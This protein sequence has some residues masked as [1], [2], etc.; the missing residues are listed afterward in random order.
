MLG[1]LAKAGVPKKIESIIV[2]ESLFNDGIGV[3][4]FIAL[5]EVLNSGSH[6]FDFSHFSILFLREA[7]GGILFGLA[8]GYVLHFI[9][10]KIDHYE[11]EV[12]LT[13]AFV[14]G[15]YTLAMALHLSGPLAMV[16]MGLLIGNYKGEAFMSDLTKEYMYK[17]WE[18]IDMIL[19]AVLFI[20]IA[21]VLVVIDFKQSYFLIAVASVIII[22]ISRVIVVYLPKILFIKMFGINNTEAKLLVWGGL[23]GGLSIALALS[24][25][26]SEEKYIILLAT[27]C[28]VVFSILIQGLTI[29]KFAKSSI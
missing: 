1:I 8:A 5:L 14:M 29:K 23:R 7:A 24:L 18:L 17:F 26:E 13:I 28:C 20:I 2:G 22:F 11:T 16:I 12:L 21:M 19:N 3:V 10:N 25:P 9:L 15:G 6:T 27:Y 4:I